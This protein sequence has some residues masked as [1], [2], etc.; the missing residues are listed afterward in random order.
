MSFESSVGLQAERVDERLEFRVQ[1]KSMAN[2]EFFK[3]G[4]TDEEIS[5]GF[6]LWKDH[7]FADRFKHLFTAYYIQGLRDETELVEKIINNLK[8]I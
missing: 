3:E 1:L 2:L 6:K 4:S 8:M 7:G 5:R